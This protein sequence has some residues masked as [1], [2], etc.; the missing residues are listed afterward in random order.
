MRF[1]RKK[2]HIQIKQVYIREAVIAPSANFIKL[3]TN[4]ICKF[5]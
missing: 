4:A 2:L 1:K 5:S 3:F